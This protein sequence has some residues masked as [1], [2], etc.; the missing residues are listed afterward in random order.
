MMKLSKNIWRREKTSDNYAH[1]SDG[2]KDGGYL[3]SQL[4]NLC[5]QRKTF[6]ISRSQM[7]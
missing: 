1:F 2:T 3:K 4:G 7:M 5:Y 6:K